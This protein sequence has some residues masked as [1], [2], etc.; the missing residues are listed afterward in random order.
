MT[1]AWIEVTVVMVDNQ[2]RLRQGY[3]TP[4]ILIAEYCNEGLFFGHLY[5]ISFQLVLV[6]FELF[7]DFA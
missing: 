5:A 4:G 1:C 6:G 2:P 7:W 3:Q